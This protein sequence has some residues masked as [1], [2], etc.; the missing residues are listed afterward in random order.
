MLG[1][2]IKYEIS[3]LFDNVTFILNKRPLLADKIILAALTCKTK[4][5]IYVSLDIYK[6]RKYRR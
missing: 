1:E 3:G 4:A 5:N 2:P 6:A